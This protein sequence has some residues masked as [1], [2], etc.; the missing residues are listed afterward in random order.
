MIRFVSVALFFWLTLYSASPAW[1]GGGW[2]IPVNPE[3]CAEDG[4][5]MDADGDGIFTHIEDNDGDGVSVCYEG[6]HLVWDQPGWVQF[7][8]ANFTRIQNKPGDLQLYMLQHMYTPYLLDW[9]YF[10]QEMTTVRT[11]GGGL[12]YSF[13]DVEGDCDDNDPNRFPGNWEV[14]F[15]GVDADC[16]PMN[17]VCIPAIVPPGWPGYAWA[18]GMKYWDC[19]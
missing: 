17:E 14:M 13:A 3:L 4:T 7:M 6:N 5:P 12:G 2:G 15:D 10:F 16:N 18:V 9:V 1:A 8:T 11:P 19:P